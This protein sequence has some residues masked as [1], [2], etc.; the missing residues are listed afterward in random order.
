[1]RGGH[2][3]A[4]AIRIDGV[5]GHPTA[6]EAGADE[7]A[8]RDGQD[9]VDGV[10]THARVGEDRQIGDGGL[11]FE[12]LIPVGR[13]AGDLAAEEDRVDTEVRRTSRP[14]RDRTAP[15]SA[16]ELGSDVAEQRDRTRSDVLAVCSDGTVVRLHYAEVA[17]EDAGEHLANIRS[18]CRPVDSAT[19]DR[20]PYQI[21]AQR[22]RDTRPHLTDDGRH[23]RGHLGSNA[24]LVWQVRLVAE[25]E[26]VDAGA[27]QRFAVAPAGIDEV[28][29][30]GN[31]IMARPAGHRREVEH[32]DDRF[33]DAEQT[34][35]QGHA[36]AL[37]SARRGL[38][39]RWACEDEV[40]GVATTTSTPHLSMRS[41]S[42]ASADASVT[43]AATCSSGATVLIATAPNLEP[44]AMTMIRSVR[45]RPPRMTSASR[46]SNSVT[47]R[48]ADARQLVLS[49]QAPGDDD[50]YVACA[51]QARNRQ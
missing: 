48:R 34:A 47:P 37:I 11:G 16:G 29:H 27:P 7:D 42:S 15:Q 20:V 6:F 35:Q 32:R 49:D 4:R 25:E 30:A 39:P 12:Q 38:P 10:L 51:Q 45:S 9:R 24:D 46:A 26:P 2:E 8:V 18:P 5:P 44:S 17:L 41:T 13:G 28:G 40:S 22:T 19:R 33:V 1:M 14:R 3:P 21:D 43:I 31:T 50:A 23:P 36:R